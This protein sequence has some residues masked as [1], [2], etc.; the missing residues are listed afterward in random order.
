MIS[1]GICLS[2]S[3][4][5]LSMIISTCIWNGLLKTQ[6]Q[7][8]LGGNTFQG[9]VKVLQ[10]LSIY[11][12]KQCPIYGAVSLIARTHRSRN[13]GVEMVVVPLTVTLSDPLTKFLLPIPV[14]LF[15]WLRGLASNRRNASTRRHN[16]DSTELKVKTATRPLCIP[17][18]SESTGKAGSFSG[19]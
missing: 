8:Q 17:Y 16:N 2:L 5:S 9:W 15:C 4:I 6:L 14:T 7:H 10:N 1:C 13:Q 11:S 3:D 18:A 19:D 12:L